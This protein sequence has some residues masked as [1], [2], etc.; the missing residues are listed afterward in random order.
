MSNN[1]FMMQ[2]LI[3]RRKMTNKE[4]IE[5]LKDLKEF[6]KHELS[7][8]NSLIYEEAYEWGRVDQIKRV[9][10]KIKEFEEN[11]WV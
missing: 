11:E 5:I 1:S 6:L 7:L 10:N 9:L 3:W 8:L 4:Q 2:F